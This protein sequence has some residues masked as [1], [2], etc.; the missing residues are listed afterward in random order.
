MRF[1]CEWCHREVSIV[2]GEKPYNEV[3]AHFTTCER[4]SP[5]TTDEQVAGLA[6][7]ITGIIADREEKRMRQAG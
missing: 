7:H 2:D 6:T 3:L 1:V 4:R 5:V